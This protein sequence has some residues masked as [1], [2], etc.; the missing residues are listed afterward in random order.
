MRGA[1]ESE[2]QEKKHWIENPSIKCH[3]NTNLTKKVFFPLDYELE[4][5]KKRITAQDCDKRNDSFQTE[6]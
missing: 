6:N 5:S 1:K 4:I 2:N 3:L